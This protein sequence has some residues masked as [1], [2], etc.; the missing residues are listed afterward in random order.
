MFPKRSQFAWQLPITNL[1]RVEVR[2]VDA[3]AVLHFECADI[4]QKRSPAF[5]FRQILSNMM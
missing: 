5:I 3:H 2:N 1:I 4:V